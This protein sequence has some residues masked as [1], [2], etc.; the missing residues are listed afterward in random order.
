LGDHV[1]QH[2]R[3]G[4][5]IAYI[6][7]NTLASEAYEN[8]KKEQIDALFRTYSQMPA[9]II[10]L[11]NNNGGNEDIAGWFAS[12][13]T[14]KEVLYGYTQ[15]R[16][17]PGHDAF[18]PPKPKLLVPAGDSYGGAV[19]CL[20]G[21]RCMSSAEWF[22]LMMKASGAVLIGD[23]TRGASGNPKECRLPNG[24][25]YRMSTWMAYDAGMQPIEE[26][27]IQPDILMAPEASF[28]GGH[29]Y[30]VERAIQELKSILSREKKSRGAPG[31]QINVLSPESWSV[32]S[33][34]GK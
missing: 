9:F 3:L 12:H 27:G 28:D 5:E 18:S 32:S 34:K 2:G 25:T 20:I 8:I 33:P 30:V 19:A 15:T 13:F 24:V 31:R 16:N 23:R 10:D 21:Q 26:R 1:V 22:T 14:A 29:D 11:R 4:D 17:G 7:I 6:R